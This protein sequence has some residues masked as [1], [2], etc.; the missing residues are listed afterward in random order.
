MNYGCGKG[1]L[2]KSEIEIHINN[3]EN[4]SLNNKKFETII[5]NFSNVQFVDEAGCKCLKEIIKDYESDKIQII[6]ACC[7]G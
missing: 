2:D 5:I 4:D 1:A 3:N 6:F 7:N